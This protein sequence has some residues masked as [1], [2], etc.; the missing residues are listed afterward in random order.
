MCSMCEVNNQTMSIYVLVC[1]TLSLLFS[2]GNYLISHIDKSSVYCWLALGI[3][4]VVHLYGG[5]VLRQAKQGFYIAKASD[6]GRYLVISYARW[7][8]VLHIPT[9]I[10]LS[11]RLLLSLHSIRAVSVYPSLINSCIRLSSLLI[12]FQIFNLYANLSAFLNR[13]VKKL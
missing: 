5:H 7:R 10:E 12:R 1:Y 9:D 6:R 3:L 8:Q 13:N 2:T 4:R 11:Y